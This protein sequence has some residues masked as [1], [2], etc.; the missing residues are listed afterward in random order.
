MLWM[1]GLDEI[2]GVTVFS[3]LDGTSLSTNILG[4]LFGLNVN[5][6]L[7]LFLKMST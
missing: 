6:Y 3:K 2:V 7:F 1:L 5:I 4:F